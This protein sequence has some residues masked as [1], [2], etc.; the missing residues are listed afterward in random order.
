MT[1]QPTNR[2]RYTSIAFGLGLATLAA[3]GSQAQTAGYYS[4]TTLNNL[5]RLN[6]LSSSYNT[7]TGGGG[8]TSLSG[9]PA[10]IVSGSPTPVGTCNCVGIIRDAQTGNVLH[11]WDTDEF[12]MYITDRTL[13]GCRKFQ[14]NMQYDSFPVVKRK[15]S[16]IICDWAPDGGGQHV[17][18]P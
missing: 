10:P 15:E 16:D 12:E 9:N 17:A 7:V 18:I 5:S 4:S 14:Y 1:Q 13:A 6:N 11:M 3:A 8:A 2:L